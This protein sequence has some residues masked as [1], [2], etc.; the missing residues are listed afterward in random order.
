MNT[1]RAIVLLGIIVA[2]V[3]VILLYSSVYTVKMMQQALVLELGAPKKVVSEPGLYTKLPLVQ[4]VRIFPKQLLNLVA[5]SQ[6]VIAQDK[7]RIV[8]DAFLR[9]RIVDPLRFYQSQTDQ[10]RANG[11]L[12]QMLNSE[13]RGVLGSQVFSAMLSSK[14]AQLMRDIRDNM[15]QETKNFGIVIVDV[16]ILH[17]DLPLQNSEAIYQRMVQERKREANEF[18]AQG[19]EVRQTI[20]SNAERDRTVLLAEATRDSEIMR[21]EGDAEKTRIL[22]EAYNQDPDFFAFY[23]S[24]QAY[25]DALPSDNTTMLVSPTGDFFRY[26]GQA[27]R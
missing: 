6:E 21:G 10:E 19:Q 24:M 4:E 12:M 27:G 1:N 3:A 8:V 25:K 23:R 26:Y 18:R 7:K 11:T 5:P 14:R 2:L 9:W 20:Q 22:A 16:R 15:N 17:A 13:V